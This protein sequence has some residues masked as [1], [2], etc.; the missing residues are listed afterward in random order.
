MK[1]LAI[2]VL[3][4]GLSAATRG[5]EIAGVNVPD[6]E[7]VEGKTL[8]LNGAGLRKKYVVAK[9]YVLGLYLETPS[10]DA[11]AILSSDQV[12]DLRMSVLR[13]VSG[14]KISEAITGGFERHWRVWIERLIV[15]A[16]AQKRVHKKS[17]GALLHL[18]LFS[19]FVVLTIGTTLLGIAHDG[20]YNF[21]HGWYYL[22]YE[23][24]MDVFGV[25]FCIGC[26]LAMYRRAFRR[27]PSLGHNRSDWWLLGLLL[28]LGVTGPILRAT[29]FPWD[30]RKAQPYLA[31]DQVDFDVP[32][33]WNGDVY[34]LS[35][36]TGHQVWRYRTGGQVKGDDGR[37][38]SGVQPSDHF[39][40]QAA[41]SA[42]PRPFCS[43]CVARTPGSSRSSS[44]AMPHVPSVLALSAIV[45]VVVKGN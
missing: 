37:T 34:A 33:Y 44:R 12:R 20:P 19:G 32:V 3:A 28:A 2:A 43:R 31:Y 18:L 11:A 29:G 27:K 13:D 42:R 7:T 36:K 41:R 1:H 8:K 9:V 10:R 17:L 40:D 39:S 22:I 24:T 4:L 15:Y 25:A 21:H 5:V 45:M 30:L 14:A 35:A 6:T 38:R 16:L 26:V 23:L